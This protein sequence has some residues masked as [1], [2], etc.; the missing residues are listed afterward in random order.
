MYVAATEVVRNRHCNTTAQVCVC[1]CF[2]VWMCMCVSVCL[3][4]LCAH[5]DYALVADVALPVGARAL[6][7]AVVRANLLDSCGRCTDK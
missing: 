1:V 7:G 2:C 5:I 4:R 3:E 6:E